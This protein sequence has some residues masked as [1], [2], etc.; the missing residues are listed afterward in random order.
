VSGDVVGAVD[1]TTPHGG[2]VRQAEAVLS[3]THVDRRFGTKQALSDV[4]FEVRSGEIHALLGPNGAGK[5]TLLRILVGLVDADRGEVRIRGARAEDVATRWSRRLFGL[6]PSGDRTFYLRISGLENLAFF[7]RLQGLSRREAI[8]RAREC[9]DAV[10]LSDV[11]RLPVGEYSHGMQKRLSIARAILM[12]PPILLVDEATHDLDPHAAERVRG[13]IR[14]AAD[15]GAAVVWTTQRVDEIRGFAERVTL[16]DRG[17]MRFVGTVSQLIAT[18][19]VRRFVLQVGPNEGRAD[20]LATASRALGESAEVSA[21][22][23]EGHWLLSLRDGVVLGDAIARLSRAGIGVVACR[24][25]R[26]GLE[27]A[28]LR[29]TEGGR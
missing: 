7:A 29:L 28:F 25:E 5:T 17:R 16:L 8:R 18:A 13:L 2:E 15:R 20:A 9:L 4:S 22:E 6:F 24:E 11:A 19:G 10:E 14:T 26:S 21:T 27:L 3:A 23:D 12:E 1:A